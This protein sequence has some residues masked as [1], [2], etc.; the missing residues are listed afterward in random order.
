M[1]GEQRERKTMEKADMVVTSEERNTTLPHPDADTGPNPVIEAPDFNLSRIHSRR[2]IG[3]KQH[4]IFRHPLG[5]SRRSSRL[6]PGALIG[7][8]LAGFYSNI[9]YEDG[10]RETKSKSEIEREVESKESL[11]SQDLK[12][13]RKPN[14]S[15]IDININGNGFGEK[16]I[17]DAGFNIADKKGVLKKFGLKK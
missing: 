14:D 12:R 1:V 15:G 10:T 3:G 9:E 13:E 8:D 7:D 5:G 17:E 2:S 4:H 6:G 16:K 11:V